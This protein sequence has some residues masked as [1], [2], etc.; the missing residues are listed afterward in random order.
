M[1]LDTQVTMKMVVTIPLTVTPSLA[2]KL[3]PLPLLG[4]LTGT[5]HWSGTLVSHPGSRKQ[6]RNLHMCAQD[7]QITRTTQQYGQQIQY[8]IKLQTRIFTK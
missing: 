6:N 3:E 8:L 5:L 7:V 4:T 1:G 2:S